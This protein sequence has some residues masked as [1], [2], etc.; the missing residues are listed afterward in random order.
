MSTT[1]ATSWAAR[2]RKTTEQAIDAINQSGK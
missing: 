2:L 1:A